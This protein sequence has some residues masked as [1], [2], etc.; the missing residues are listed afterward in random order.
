MVLLS[1]WQKDSCSHQSPPLL[2]TVKW[3]NSMLRYQN[4]CRREL[5]HANDTKNN[6]QSLVFPKCSSSIFAFILPGIVKFIYSVKF[7]LVSKF[8]VCHIFC[9][10][11]FSLST[12][13][14]TSIV[15]K[16][17]NEKSISTWYLQKITGVPYYF[18]LLF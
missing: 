7:K 11:F 13:C 17:L 2:S 1:A 16:F 10:L 6:H 4:T 8:K 18:F 9:S 3:S 5:Q 15:V 12:I 14:D